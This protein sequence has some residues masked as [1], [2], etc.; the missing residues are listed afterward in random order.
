MRV[1]LLAALLMLVLVPGALADPI[2]SAPRS[3]SHAIVGDQGLG[4]LVGE[5]KGTNR[6]MDESLKVESAG[7]LYLGDLRMTSRRHW[8]I[9][10]TSEPYYVRSDSFAIELTGEQPRLRYNVSATLTSL[11]NPSDTKK[12]H[13]SYELEAVKFSLQGVTFTDTSDIS[14]EL[15]TVLF[16]RQ[17]SSLYMAV[18]YVRDDEEVVEYA[19]FIPQTE[20]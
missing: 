3:E 15:R 12:F 11:A 2:E 5:W 14:D 4:W 9:G 17:G 18:S 19:R 10:N 20:E 7:Q 16:V 6:R 8:R 1:Y 13:H